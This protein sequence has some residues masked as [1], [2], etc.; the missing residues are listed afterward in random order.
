M[1]DMNDIRID[2]DSMNVIQGGF[3]VVIRAYYHGKPVAIKKLKNSAT[4][5]E[6]I[7]FEQECF[8]TCKTQHPNVLSYIGIIRDNP[9]N[10]LALVTEWCDAGDL[11]TQIHRNWSDFSTFNLIDI[12]LQI[13]EGVGYLHDIGIIHRDIKGENVF[14]IE[15]R[16]T[17]K[18]VLFTA[19]IGDFGCSTL[20]NNANPPIHTLEGTVNFMVYY[21]EFIMHIFLLLKKLLNSRPPKFCFQK[22]I[23]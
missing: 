17:E 13:A 22:I 10:R 5:N 15:N 3:G 12:A 7:T 11:T 19:K 6:K 16:V 21:K 4:A 18:A 2:L 9:S 20:I 1:I 23:R 14:L 8:L